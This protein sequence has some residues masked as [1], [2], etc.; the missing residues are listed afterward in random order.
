MTGICSTQTSAGCEKL[1]FS[2]FAVFKIFGL[3]LRRIRIIVL[4]ASGNITVPS[5]QGQSIELMYEKPGL[6][7]TCLSRGTAAYVLHSR[8][9]PS[10]HP[11]GGH[12]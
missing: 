9:F 4:S 1:N 5:F 8:P 3:I 2:F 11:E 7:Q 10:P 6:C 12:G